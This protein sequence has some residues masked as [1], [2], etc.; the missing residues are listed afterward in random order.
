MHTSAQK[1]REPPALADGSIDRV[2]ELNPG[3][4][5]MGEAQR[6][7]GL[8]GVGKIVG[9]EVAASA[10]FPTL[11]AGTPGGY[12]TGLAFEHPTATSV[13]DQDASLY[14]TPVPITE[15]VS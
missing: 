6:V 13:A 2:I 12:S 15:R 1:R 8:P 3:G 10:I 7:F 14:A 9:W 4:R 11:L 5:G